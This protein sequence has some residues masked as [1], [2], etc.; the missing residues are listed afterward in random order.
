MIRILDKSIENR[1]FFP[2]N[3]IENKEKYTLTLKSEFTLE[4]YTFE[5][6]D[7]DTIS[8]YYVFAIDFSNVV[9]GEYKYHIDDVACGI[10]QIGD[11]TPSK[12]IKN[13]NEKIEYISYEG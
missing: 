8:D 13:Y 5:V 12:H 1:V 9:D 2:K 10:I 3:I 11:F 4:E 6:E 7:L